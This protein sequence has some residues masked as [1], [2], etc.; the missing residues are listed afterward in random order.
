MELI[1]Q[2]HDLTYDASPVYDTDWSNEISQPLLDF[3]S[4]LTENHLVSEVKEEM[5]IDLAEPET[6]EEVTN[7]EVN[8]TVTHLEYLS[9]TQQDDLLRKFILQER[10]LVPEARCSECLN[11]S[12]KNCQVLRNYKSYS[13]YLAYQRM[14]KDMKLVEVEDHFKVMCSYD[15]REVVEEKF[16]PANT[17]REEALR[18]M[19]AVIVR[20]M[21]IGRLE[22]FQKQMDEMESMGTI[23]ALS[24]FEIKDLETQPHHFKKL[25]YTLSSTSASTP[26]RVLRDSTS[27]VPNSGGIFS[28]ISQVASGQDIGDG[29]TCIINHRMGKYAASLDASLYRVY[30]RVHNRRAC[31]HRVPVSMT[32]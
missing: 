32:I 9:N 26:L 8:D 25:N 18:A 4:N 12:C 10:T 15:Y 17:N 24:E 30:V 13:A 7:E 14:F 3:L 2:R 21:K 27:K 28:V 19:N 22:E 11:K 31:A 5:V 1:Y 6:G 16:A 29:L 20:L 23:V